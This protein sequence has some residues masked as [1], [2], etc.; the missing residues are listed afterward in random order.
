MPDLQGITAIRLSIN[1]LHDILIHCFATL[2]AIA[3]VVRRAHAILA[4]VEVLGVV[5]IL[6]W[7]G[8]DCVEDL[9]QYLANVPSPTSSTRSTCLQVV[10]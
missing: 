10:I 6:V 5:D 3:P 1:H 8:L 2:V 4:D 7:T 9:W